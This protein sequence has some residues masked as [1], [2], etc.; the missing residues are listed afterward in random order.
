MQPFP[1][2]SSVRYL[3]TRG[4][5][6]VVMR[7]YMLEAAVFARLRDRLAHQSGMTFVGR[8]PEL[9]G[10]SLV[11]EVSRDTTDSF[12]RISRP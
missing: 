10:E 8:F 5:R 11:Y 4:V 6:Y 7:Q 3:Q 1:D 9:V 12:T 2:A